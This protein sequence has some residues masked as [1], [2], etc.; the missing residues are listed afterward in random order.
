MQS[1]DLVLLQGSAPTLRESSERLQTYSENFLLEDAV[2]ERAGCFMDRGD[3]NKHLKR[4][5]TGHSNMIIRP[6]CYIRYGERRTI[7]RVM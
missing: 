2:R 7:K 4:D 3:L 5:E 1:V 6:L